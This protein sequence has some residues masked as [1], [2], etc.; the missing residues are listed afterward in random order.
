MEIR[1]IEFWWHTR[2]V[3]LLLYVQKT[4]GRMLD[5]LTPTVERHLT[6]MRAIREEIATERDELKRRVAWLTTKAAL[7]EKGQK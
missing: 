5:A 1:D 4:V 2:T 6:A 7:L 3:T